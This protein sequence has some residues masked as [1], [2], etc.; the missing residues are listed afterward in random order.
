[1]AQQFPMITIDSLKDFGANVDEGLARCLN[2]EDFYI[3]MVNLGLNDD[4]FNKLIEFVESKNLDSAFETAHALKG[5]VGNLA[6]TPL[7]KPIE[8]ITELLR[9]HT[10][11]DYS[12]LCEE[13]KTQRN[14]LLA[15]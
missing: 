2:K 3:K 4:K 8:Q 9:N 7:L 14:K 13:I 12:E 5:V 6:L 15:L 10:E 11:T 1:M